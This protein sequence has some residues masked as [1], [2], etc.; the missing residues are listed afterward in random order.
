[1]QT[2]WYSTVKYASHTNILKTEKDWETARTPSQSVMVSKLGLQ[3]NYKWKVSSILTRCFVLLT[4]CHILAMLC[5]KKKENITKYKGQKTI[6]SVK[7]WV[8]KKDK[9]ATREAI[10]NKCISKMKNRIE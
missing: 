3:I 5:K 1:M 8:R 4:L 6:E 9:M 10:K 7:V 2:W